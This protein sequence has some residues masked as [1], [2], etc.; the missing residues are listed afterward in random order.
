MCWYARPVRAILLLGILALSAP[1]VAAPAFELRALGV[2]GGDWDDNLSCYL[3][4]RPAQ[5]ATLMLDGGSVMNGIVRALERDGRLSP[6]ASWTTRMRAVQEVLRPLR[7]LLVTHSHL[8]HI[9]GFLVRSTVDL[10][11][12][13]GGRPTFEIV[14]LP[15][16]IDA[17]HAHALAPPLWVDFSAVPPQNPTFRLV[18]LSPGATHDV[19]GFTVRTIPLVH[20]VPSAAFLVTAESGDAYLHLGDTGATTEVWEVARPLLVAGKLRAVAIEVSFPAR[21]EELAARTGHL[22]PRTLVGELAKLAGLPASADAR[23]VAR[24]LGGLAIVALHIKALV[25]DDVASELKPLQAAGL[26]IVIPAQGGRYR[27]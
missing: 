1:A 9:G 23:A 2:L 11:L 10:A 18:P 25:Y 27:F 14:G 4:G 20:P 21:D 12:L 13:Q 24:A 5:P 16:T 26:H 17:L 8:D 19:G 15:D 7:A 22:T 3:L 6:S